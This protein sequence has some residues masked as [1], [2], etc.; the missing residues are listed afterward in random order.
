MSRRMRYS[1]A[2]FMMRATVRAAASWMAVLVIVRKIKGNTKS[3]RQVRAAQK[4]SS[5]IVFYTVVW[6][7]GDVGIGLMTI[8][9][10]AKTAAAVAWWFGCFV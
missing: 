6:D 3:H 7:L 8:F 4:R 1:S 9:N 10:M 5:A 2:S